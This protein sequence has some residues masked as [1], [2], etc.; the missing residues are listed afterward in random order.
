[1]RTIDMGGWTVQMKLEAERFE[2][3]EAERFSFS[4]S[5]SVHKIGRWQKE[6]SL[7]LEMI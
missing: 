7:K 4:F 1:V 6:R 5:F 2:G 3:F